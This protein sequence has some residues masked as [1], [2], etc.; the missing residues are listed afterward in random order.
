MTALLTCELRS[1]GTKLRHER[2]DI[3][4]RASG[5]QA[6]LGIRLVLPPHQHSSRTRRLPKDLIVPTHIPHGDHGVL[7]A[8]PHAL[9]VDRLRQVP[10]LLLGVDRIVIPEEI[11]RPPLKSPA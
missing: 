3:D 6:L 5:S 4:D 2:S 11:S 7:A 8:V 1:C 10:D 9:D